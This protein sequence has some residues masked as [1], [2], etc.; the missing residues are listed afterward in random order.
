MAREIELKLSL[1]A[2]E[3]R[4]FLRS[5]L[6]QHAS[7]RSSE[8]LVNIYYDTPDLALHCNGIALRLRQS[9]RRWLQTVKCAGISHGGLSSRPEWETPY[10]GQFDFTCIDDSATRKL[11]DRFKSRLVPVFETNFL[12]TTWKVQEADTALIVALDRGTIV[13]NSKPETISELE[14]EIDTGS[15]DAIFSLADH[16][17]AAFTLTPGSRSKA[18][19]GYRLFIGKPDKPARATPVLLDK[20]I[21]PIAAFRQIT[22]ACLDHLQQNHPGAAASDDIEYIHQM[23]VSMRRIRAALRLFKPVLPT[24]FDSQ[25]LPSLHA[26]MAVLGHAR[27]LDVLTTEIVNPVVLAIPAE[28]RVMALSGKVAERRHAARLAAS[29]A[30]NSPGYGRMLLLAMRELHRLANDEGPPTRDLVAFVNARLGQLQRRMMRLIRA[31]RH[32]EPTSLHAL[33]IGAKRL[34]YALEFFSPLMP[35]RQAAKLLGLL[36]E[37]QDTL[38]Q[39]NDLANAGTLLMDCA[40]GAPD[41]REAVS[42]IGGWHGRRYAKLLQRIP[43]ATKQLKKAKLP[44]A[45]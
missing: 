44:K 27:D 12:R 13:A 18:E 30:L 3:Q 40:E 43:L 9:R 11:L 10:G 1:P 26:L 39:L 36:A 38:G 14:I 22:Y 35:A 37:L 5:N 19:R 34:R 15:V 33:R 29:L 28:P 4:R 6:L 25:L 8:R 20:V 42:L 21:S 41:L 24:G 23:R 32:D 7:S 45:G 17:A 31:A 2:D 16:L